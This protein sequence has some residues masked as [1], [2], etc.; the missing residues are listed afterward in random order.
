[1]A[2]TK[3]SVCG[4]QV[5]DK[6]ISCSK[7]GQPFRNTTIQ[8]TDKKWKVVKLVAWVTIVGGLCMFVSGSQNGGFQNPKTGAGLSLLCIGIILL[9]VGKFGAWW[10]NK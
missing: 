2:L 3:C 6:A 4:A 5:S 8:L 1:M 10:T 7:C 9:V